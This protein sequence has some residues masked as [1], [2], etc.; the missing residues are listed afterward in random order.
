[1]DSRTTAALLAG[2][3]VVCGAGFFFASEANRSALFAQEGVATT[4]RRFGISMGESEHSAVATLSKVGWRYD[5]R[6][7]GGN[8]VRHAYPA[9]KTM[10]VLF[11]KSWRKGTICLISTSARI[12]A[13]E[14]YFAPFSPEL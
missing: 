3:V 1:M 7:N 12:D 9:T 13:V 4:G 14:W 8:C 11:D 6:Q 10:T 2:V 5:H